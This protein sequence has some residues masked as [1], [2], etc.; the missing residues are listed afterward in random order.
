M[1]WEIKIKELSALIAEIKK[2]KSLL[3]NINIIKKLKGGERI[4]QIQ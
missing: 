3:R 2:T 4:W 1:Q